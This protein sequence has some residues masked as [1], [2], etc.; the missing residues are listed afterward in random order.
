MPVSDASPEGGDERFNARL[1]E[2]PDLE[3]AVRTLVDTL[4]P[5]RNLDDTALHVKALADA[6]STAGTVEVEA[7]LNA[8]LEEALKG[9]DTLR[10]ALQTAKRHLRTLDDGDEDDRAAAQEAIADGLNQL[11]ALVADIKNI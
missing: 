1:D 6:I 5:L 3:S 11:R 2:V 8:N 9:A 7:D 4:S 10:Q